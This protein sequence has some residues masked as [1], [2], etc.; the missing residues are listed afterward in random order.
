MGPQPGW[1]LR[2]ALARLWVHEDRQVDATILRY[3]P[4]SVNWHTIVVNDVLATVQLHEDWAPGSVREVHV[5]NNGI[6]HRHGKPAAVHR[7]FQTSTGGL[8]K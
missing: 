3:A 6:V 8:V 2:A 5:G 7:C 4:H 1:M